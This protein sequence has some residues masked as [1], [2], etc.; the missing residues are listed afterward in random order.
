MS[1]SWCFSSSQAPTYRPMKK[2]LTDSMLK[3]KL[4]RLARVLSARSEAFPLEICKA[5]IQRNR[6][7]KAFSR[8]N[9]RIAAFKTKHVYSCAKPQSFVS[10]VR[11][12]NW[13]CKTIC[14]GEV[15]TLL[16]YFTK[17]DVNTLNSSYWS[18]YG[19]I[20]KANYKKSLNMVNF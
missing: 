1:V 13:F 10:T 6:R 3:K 15:D 5:L 18:T 8:G 20:Y 7:I 12:C 16:T 19:I 14:S 11:F 9:H 2:F 17:W 4:K